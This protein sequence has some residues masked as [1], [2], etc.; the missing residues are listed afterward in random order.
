MFCFFR[1]TG[2]N[3]FFSSDYDLTDVIT[4]YLR[5]FKKTIAL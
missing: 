2:T 1:Q 3:F 4:N 5:D